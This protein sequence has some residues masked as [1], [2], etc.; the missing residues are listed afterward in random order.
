MHR[1]FIVFMLCV[2]IQVIM[3][4]AVKKQNINELAGEGVEFKRVL[5]YTIAQLLLLLSL[6]FF[7]FDS[8]KIS[9]I[10]GIISLGIFLNFRKMQDSVMLSGSIL[11]AITTWA[12]YFFS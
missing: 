6:Y 2:S 4:M 12:L 8:S 11:M 3:S 5:I 7:Q 9:W 1:V 10:A